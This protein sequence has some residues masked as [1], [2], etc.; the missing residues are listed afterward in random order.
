LDAEKT[1][2]RVT[3]LAAGGDGIGHLEDGRVVFIEGAAPGDLVTLADLRLS[4]RMARASVGEILERSPD[5][6][7]PRCAHF[8]VCG[9]CQWQ[10]L[11]YPAQLAAKRQ[12]LSDAL[13]R[14]GGLD[15]P[16]TFEIVAS[17]DPY[18][19]RARARLVQ[20]PD[21]RLGYRKR[22]SH[23]VV[24]VH[25]CPILVPAAATALEAWKALAAKP[26]KAGKR[27]RDPEWE[28][29]A[30][31]K[32]SA[33]ALIGPVVAGRRASGAIEIEVLG[34][35]L[36]AR[37]GSFLQGNALLWDALAAEVRAQCLTGA[38]TAGRPAEEIGEPG[39]LVELYAGIGF[40]TLPLARAG[41]SGFAFESGHEAVRD[42]E[43]NLERSGLADRMKVVAGRV[44]SRGDWAKR[45]AAADLLVMDPPRVGLAEEMRAAIAAD[46]P[47]R[48]VYV[49]CDPATLARDLR[50]LVDAGYRIADL[51]AFDL[52]PQ[53]PHVE[54]VVRLER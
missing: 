33:P 20:S 37:S 43:E 54:A 8:G 6:A 49:S 51:R 17:P 27:P 29:L 42:L 31:S 16:S 26:R 10:H 22:G 9:G 23:E 24:A 11:E 35:S 32:P 28:I 48:C 4:A 41:F 47:A 52:F 46:G 53:T 21:G 50:G 5:R 3:G 34:E 14:I 15:F 18:G 30:G 39:A 38:G 7:R 13:T 19:Y 36:Q 40:L 1:P 25:E 12:I 2:V 44:E 45:F